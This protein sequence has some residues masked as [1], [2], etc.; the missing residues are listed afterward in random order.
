MQKIVD[1]LKNEPLS[2]FFLWYLISSAGGK[3]EFSQDK[4]AKISVGN[5]TQASELLNNDIDNCF[6]LLIALLGTAACQLGNTSSGM[7]AKVEQGLSVVSTWT[8]D[9]VPND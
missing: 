8:G 4:K 5:E 2:V 1:L 3:T 6:K 7:M 9:S